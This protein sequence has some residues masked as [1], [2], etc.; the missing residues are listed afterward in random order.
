LRWFACLLV[1]LVALNAA[2]AVRWLAL[3]RAAGPDD[4]QRFMALLG[5]VD[6][7]GDGRLSREEFLRTGGSAAE[8]ER[9]DLNHDHQVDVDELRTAFDR[10][11]PNRDPGQARE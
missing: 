7:D 2:L 5:K 4:R 9:A 10:E 3:R 6:A 1:A 8:F 11:D